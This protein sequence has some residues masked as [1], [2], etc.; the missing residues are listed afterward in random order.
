[1]TAK[2]HQRDIQPCGICGKG[3][4]HAGSPT[5]YRVTIDHLIFNPRAIQ[6]Q[7]GLEQMLGGNAALAHAM[8]TQEA[9]AEP[10][11]SETVLVCQEC[12]MESPECIAVLH[13]VALENNGSSEASDA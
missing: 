3:L 7:H 11:T 6:R 2:L 9:M 12:A 4:M 1:M 13:G 5:A 8:G 10:V